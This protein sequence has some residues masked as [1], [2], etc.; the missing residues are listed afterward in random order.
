MPREQK[1]FSFVKGV[2][3][4]AAVRFI[5]WA[6]VYAKTRKYLCQVYSFDSFSVPMC[7]C[8]MLN[9]VDAVVIFFYNISHFKCLCYYKN[10]PLTQITIH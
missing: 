2:R 1:L 7:A 5:V 9:R 8:T 10:I 4:Y 3:L 6:K